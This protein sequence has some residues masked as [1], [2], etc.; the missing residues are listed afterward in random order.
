MKKILGMSLVVAMLVS[1]LFALPVGAQEYPKVEGVNVW[2]EKGFIT[3]E[4][5]GLI[6]TTCFYSVEDFND[7]I[8]DPDVSFGTWLL[9]PSKYNEN[10]FN[11]KYLYL[12]H[13]VSG[14][15]SSVTYE[16]SSVTVGANSIDIEITRI[17]PDP[18]MPLL[19]DSISW[20]LVLEIN[21]DFSNKHVSVDIV[22]KGLQVSTPRAY[23]DG[24]TFTSSQIVELICIPY[25]IIYYTLA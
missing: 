11:D 4:N 22:T 15:S 8:N 6:P 18:D 14:S 7:F 3:K 21:K 1:I 16:I 2:F 13:A 12:S 17:M 20:L 10:F 9:D 24:G 25:T 23:P 5:I 19:P